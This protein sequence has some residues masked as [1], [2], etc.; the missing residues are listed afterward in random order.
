M[1]YFNLLI[2]S[3]KSE[4]RDEKVGSVQRPRVVVKHEVVKNPQKT[5]SEK[6]KG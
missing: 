4:M 5:F 2:S 1:N 3:S 6:K